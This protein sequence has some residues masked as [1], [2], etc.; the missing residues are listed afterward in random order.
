M[1]ST[2]G[3]W[4][5]WAG[6]SIGLPFFENGFD[7]L[8]IVLLCRTSEADETFLLG[9][10]RQAEPVDRLKTKH[11]EFQKRLMTS[12]A[13]PPPEEIPAPTVTKRP[14]LALAPS[15]SSH[16]SKAGSISG[17]FPRLLLSPSNLGRTLGHRFSWTQTVRR[18]GLPRSK[19]PSPS[20]KLALAR[21]ASRR[22][23][24]R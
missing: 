4:N 10:N 21:P 7:N 19:K 23:S 16:K 2:R 5:V 9:I 12:L 11:T 15:K 1:R 14:A 3:F 22:T 6:E 13:A 8:T 18:V 17:G 20:R 24:R